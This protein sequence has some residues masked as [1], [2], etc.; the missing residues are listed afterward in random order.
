[1]VITVEQ[2]LPDVIYSKTEASLIIESLLNG[3]YNWRA[4]AYVEGGE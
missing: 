2:P 3:S 1:M 4:W